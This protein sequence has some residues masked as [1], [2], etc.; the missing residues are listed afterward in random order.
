MHDVAA[1][2]GVSTSTVSRAL[3]G[4]NN[5]LPETAARVRAVAEDL[6]F[7]V[8]A[9]AAGLASGKVKRVAVLLGSSLTDWFSGEIL[10]AIVRV[11]RGAGYDL[12]L[13]RVHGAMERRS[14]FESMPARRNA[15]A[16]IVASFQL[17]PDE[18]A[19]LGRLGIPMVYLNQHVDGYPGVGIDDQAVGAAAAEHLVGRGYKHLVYVGR[20]MEPGFEWSA[21]ARG[22]GFSESGVALGVD[23]PRTRLIDLEPSG[24]SELL[25][26]RE[27]K[28]QVM[29]SGDAVGVLAEHDGLATRLLHAL[30]HENVD[31]PSHVGVMGVDGQEWGTRL[32]LTTIAQPVERL[33]STAS[34]IALRLAR[35]E[36][37]AQ[38]HDWLELPTHLRE[39][40]TT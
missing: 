16:M 4:E 8:T 28:S 10:D 12:L 3:R 7:S 20:R 29:K 34:E 31:V 1:A 21:Q 33:A 11:L 9:S 39:G 24:T 19:I 18:Q 22:V 26:A 37:T 5:V 6:G 17:E 2:A 35:G 38:D 30:R 32:G 40:T 13:Y 36:A 23:A 27:L 14:F 15:D 25:L